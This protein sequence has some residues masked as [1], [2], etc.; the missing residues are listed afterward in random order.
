MPGVLPPNILVHVATP[1]TYV[2]DPTA[3]EWI[4]G[5]PGS[6]SATPTEGAP[7][8]CVLFMPGPGGSQ[9]TAYRPKVVRAPTLLYNPT[10]AD[11]SPVVVLGENELLV[12]AD[13]LAPWMGGVS[14]ARWLCD[15]DPQPFGPPGQVYGLMATLRMIKD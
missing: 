5:E 3:V 2:E 14:P 10:R 8:P 1:V 4:E 9:D 11:N 12:K 13:E 7:F 15:G 6:S